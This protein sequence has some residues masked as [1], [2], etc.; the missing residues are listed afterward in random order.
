VYGKQGADGKQKKFKAS[1]CAKDLCKRT[2]A[3]KPSHFVLTAG[4]MSDM[5]YP[6]PT[7]K[8]DGTLEIEEG[9]VTTQPAGQGIAR[10]AILSVFG[11]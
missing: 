3:Y 11:A 4:D 9:F 2:F 1:T 7:L 10:A 5:V 8:E 6:L